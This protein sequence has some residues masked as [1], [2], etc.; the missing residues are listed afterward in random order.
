MRHLSFWSSI[1][2]IY[3]TCHAELSK[4][5]IQIPDNGIELTALSAVQI[6]ILFEPPGVAVQIDQGIIKRMHPKRLIHLKNI[7]YGWNIV[8]KRIHKVNQLCPTGIGLQFIRIVVIG[9]VVTVVNQIRVG[10]SSW[11]RTCRGIALHEGALFGAQVS[12][13]K[14][15]RDCL[16]TCIKP[17]LRPIYVDYS[18]IRFWSKHITAGNVIGKYFP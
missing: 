2:Q 1:T 8:L 11:T 6:V 7:F 12:I 13:N 18:I 5:F 14:S 15:F 16:R 3:R 4:A 10:S 17:H 9:A